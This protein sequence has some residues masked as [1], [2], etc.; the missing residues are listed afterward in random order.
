MGRAAAYV[1][2]HQRAYGIIEKK[3]ACTRILVSHGGHML[4]EGLC[5]VLHG[6]RDEMCIL[7]SAISIS[8]VASS[9]GLCADDLAWRTNTHAV[10][11]AG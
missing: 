8:Y 10:C 5:A 6:S 4:V 2:C 3:D 1:R 7:D 11:R 9:H